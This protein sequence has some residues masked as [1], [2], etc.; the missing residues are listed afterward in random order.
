M[1]ILDILKGDLDKLNTAVQKD[2]QW[3]I[4]EFAKGWKLLATVG[5]TIDVDIRGIF[6]FIAKHQQQIT[7]DLHSAL[8]ALTDVGMLIPATAPEAAIIRTALTAIQAGAA[9]TTV[10][11]NSVVA[12]ATPLSTAKN[13]F[14]ALK[15]AQ[16]A[17]NEV[18][19]HATSKPTP[20]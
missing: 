2:Q 19:I 9:A 16:S 6:D 18:I 14:D 12:G 20:K 5:H 7:D 13:A 17:V 1:S 3:V 10:L 15:K 4:N 8:A 11:G